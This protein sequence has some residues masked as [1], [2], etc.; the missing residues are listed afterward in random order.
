MDENIELN[1]LGSVIKTAYEGQSDTNAFTDDEK[2][3]LA[4]ME[5][6]ST[7]NSSDAELRDRSTHT[8]T[9][10]SST[11]IDLPNLL[12]GKVDVSPGKTL[13]DTNFTQAEKDKLAGLED[14]HFKGVHVGLIALQ[15]AYPTADVGDYASVDEGIE[16]VNWYAWDQDTSEWVR[17]IGE[18]TEITP[19]QVKQYYESNPDTNAFTNDEK[20]K[21]AAITNYV[22]SVN[23]SSGNVVLNSESVG[24]LPDDYQ[25]EWNDI[26]NKPDDFGSSWVELFSDNVATRDYVTVEFDP[27]DFRNLD[28]NIIGSGPS[29]NQ[30]YL[31]CQ[32]RV[33]G[34][35]L[36]DGYLSANY[37]QASAGGYV[38]Q[39]NQNRA[40]LSPV[41]SNSNEWTGYYSIPTDV[42]RI[43][44]GQGVMSNMSP[45]SQGNRRD[46]TFR[47]PQ[48]G[49]ADAIRLFW[50]VS[51]G[52]VNTFR[53]GRVEIHGLRN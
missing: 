44:F 39:T 20:A 12:Q 1:T 15:S 14:A 10:S 40:L 43:G 49:T 47:F 53:T 23:G 35:W 52:T 3:K 5:L 42:R 26:L 38:H 4:D 2:S 29:I 50:A 32:V 6:Q 28:F 31:Y 17:R 33:D 11:I 9:Q 46:S 41:L 7:H 21:L 37:G 51:A 22:L 25:P 16:G 24:A 8:G 18:S 36:T 27:A 45:L 19:A 13:S 48:G 30:S 34:V